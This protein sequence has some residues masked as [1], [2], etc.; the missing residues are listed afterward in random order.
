MTTAPTITEQS[1]SVG[2]VAPSGRGSAPSRSRITLVLATILAGLSAGFFFTFQISVTRGLAIVGDTTYLTTFQAINDTIRNP[3][4][5]V[6][7]FGTIPAIAAA[8]LVNRRAPGTTRLLI[9]VALVLAV[10]VVAVTF[11]GS[12]PLNRE[13]ADH[14]TATATQARLDF[15]DTWNQ[16]NLI[17]TLAGIGAFAALAAATLRVPGRTD[18]KMPA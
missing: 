6:V 15:E 18:R 5:A 4:F 8:Q 10:T 14:T 13:L 2:L 16:L 3:W 1:P 7:F 9:G 12:V 17:R 11:A